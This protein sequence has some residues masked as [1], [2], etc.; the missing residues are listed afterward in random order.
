M[1]PAEQLPQQQYFIVCDGVGGHAKGEVASKLAIDVWCKF[2]EKEPPLVVANYYFSEG[3]EYVKQQFDEAISTD[4]GLKDMATTLTLLLFNRRNAHIVHLGDSRVYHIRNG[5]I[6]FQTR[7]HSLVNQLLDSGVITEEEAIQ[8]PQKNIITKALMHRL[9][10][11]VYLSYQMIP[12][13]QAN[14]YFLLCTD[15]VVEGFPSN[16]KIEALFAANTDLQLLA[17]ELNIQC[18][19]LS[20]DNYTYALI[21]I[22]PE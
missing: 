2:L 4:E 19:A 9:D 13:L 1:Y 14:D 20:N 7:D 6:Q 11:N 17:E 15:G 22:L 18:K 21:Q 8:H 10:E 12:E 3:F 16:D 5:K